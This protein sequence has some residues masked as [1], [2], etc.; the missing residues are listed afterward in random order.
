MSRPLPVKSPKVGAKLFLINFVILNKLRI[1]FICNKII[2]IYKKIISICNDEFK[3]L[4]KV[5]SK[6]ELKVI[7]KDL[8][9]VI[10]EFK[11]IFKHEFK[12]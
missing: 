10:S 3:A 6:D 8:F 7:F 9:K 4:F 12:A 1:I 5:R 2:S 11:V